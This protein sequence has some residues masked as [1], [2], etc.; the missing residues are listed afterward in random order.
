MNLK[1][2]SLTTVILTTLFFCGCYAEKATNAE[3]P[4]LVEKKI[5]PVEEKLNSMTLNE[6]IGQM[7]M[8]GVHGKEINDDINFMLNQYHV[9]GIIF[10]DR[11][12]D[13]KQQVKNF[14]D[15]LNVT[16]NEKVP[17]FIAL[18]EEGGRVARMKHDLTAPPSQESIGA[19]GNPAD[20]ETY[21]KQ[22]ADELNKIG[23]NINFAPVADVGSRDTRSFSDN[24]NT[25][26][27]FLDSA[28]KG[29]EEKKFFYCLKHF[30]GIGRSKVDPHKDISL[31]D[32]DKNTLDAE[33]ILPFKKI[34]ATHDNKNFMVM[35]GHLKY[36]AL[37]TENTASVSKNIVT[38][39]LRDELNF[40]GVVI[41][42]D[43]GMGAVANYDDIETL[44]VKAV[45]AG[46]DIILSCH[47]Y[48]KQQ[49]AYLS[50]L[51][52]VENGEIS[53]ERINESVRRILKMKF[54]LKRD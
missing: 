9:G 16:A 52:A 14:V 24:A 10:F 33:D 53:E 35:I 13:N 15:A 7:I 36:S 11:N 23:V 32:V 38:N 41:T 34:I 49:R 30:P 47:E 50:I 3:V 31:I 8:I 28:A 29:Y 51:K 27:E 54:A 20:A 26:A 25:V 22:T 12:M 2:F 17:L 5:D 37:D 6:K 19:G 18:D 42:D 44:S 45:Q 39:L 40:Q 21:A 46:V 48:D 1:I 4:E 43:L